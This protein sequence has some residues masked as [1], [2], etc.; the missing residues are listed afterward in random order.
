MTREEADDELAK[1]GPEDLYYAIKYACLHDVEPEWRA[2]LARAT[3]RE[4]RQTERVLRASGTCAQTAL[5]PRGVAAVS[6]E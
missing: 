4:R 1:Y 3:A 5:A 2:A 6:W